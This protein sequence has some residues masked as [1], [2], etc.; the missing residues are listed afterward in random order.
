ML[1]IHTELESARDVGVKLSRKSSSHV[2]IEEN[3]QRD[4]LWERT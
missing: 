3:R 4:T 1:T 2:K